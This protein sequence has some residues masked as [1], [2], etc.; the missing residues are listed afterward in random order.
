[1]DILHE[2]FPNR[3]Q[4][5]LQCTEAHAEEIQEIRIRVHSPIA[6]WM[7]GREYSVRQDGQLCP[8][9]E[10]GIR[11]E[12]KDLEEC[13][14]H[15]CHSSLYAYEEELRR[16]YLTVK[17]GHR[18]GIG[19]QVVM[20]EDGR[21]RTIKNVSFLNVRIA[22]QIFNVS[23]PILYHLYENSKIHNS[24][25]IS[26]PGFG[27][28]TLLRDMVRQISNGNAYG[29]GKNCS[30]IDERSEIAGCYRGVPQLDVGIRTDVL[31]SCPKSVGMMMAIRA[32]GPQVVVVD[33]LGTSEDIRALFSVIRS[34]CSI[35]A[36]IHGDS[37]ESVGEKSFLKQIME[38]RIFKRY[39]VICNKQHE[40]KIFN[41]ELQK[42]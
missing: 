40:T 37:L 29:D 22:H 41:G 14:M 7:R 32:M 28:T 2:L 30:V 31:D 20:K 1:M 10:E 33:E 16:G 26:P 38:E 36:T 17:G 11:M 35:L 4:R 23:K 5:L 34:G 21:I 19:G 12:R 27:K 3:M 42:C 15:I 25:I 18:I 9:M 8:N 6:I 39:I 13:I 24:L